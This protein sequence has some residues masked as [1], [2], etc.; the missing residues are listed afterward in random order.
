MFTAAGCIN[1][2]V[3]RHGSASVGI[4]EARVPMRVRLGYA[5]LYGAMHRAARVR[6]G[7]HQQCSCCQPG[8]GARARNIRAT[9]M[10]FGSAGRKL[11][12]R[13]CTGSALACA[14]S[15]CM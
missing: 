10:C 2:K 13:L 1:C 6:L 11:Q 12:V 9:I 3:S 5:S 8:L 4:H 7:Q 14:A 15:S